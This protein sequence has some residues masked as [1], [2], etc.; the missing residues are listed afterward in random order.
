MGQRKIIPQEIKQEILAKVRS[1]ER[2]VDLAQQYA[3]SDKSIYTWLQKATGDSVV[4]V[5]QYHKLKR[6]KE[7]LKNHRGIKLKTKFRGKNRAG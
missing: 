7:E 1:G 4:S 6:E 2:V 5:V 3:V